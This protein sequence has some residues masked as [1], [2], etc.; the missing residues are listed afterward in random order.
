MHAD[1]FAVLVLVHFHDGVEAFF[2][3]AAVGGEAYDGEDDAGAFVLGAVAPDFEEF[4]RVA[5]VDA[6]AGCAAGVACD[7]GEVGAA[8]AEG[9]AAVV[10]V[11]VIDG[12]VWLDEGMEKICLRVEGVLAWF[13]G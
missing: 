2:Q 11:A 5:G 9:G 6:V 8:D 3:G 10:G 7:D 4:R 12:L 13:G 1:L